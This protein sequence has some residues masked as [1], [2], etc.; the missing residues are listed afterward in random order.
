M[1]LLEMVN[2]I[3]LLNMRIMKFFSAAEPDMP[4]MDGWDTGEVKLELKYWMFYY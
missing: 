1:M 2:L 3:I 4:Y